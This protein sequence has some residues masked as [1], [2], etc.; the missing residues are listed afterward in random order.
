[1]KIKNKIYGDFILFLI[2]LLQ[3]LLNTNM[4]SGGNISVF[5]DTFFSLK[6]LFFL[7]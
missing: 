7:L 6:N 1:M 2:D 3:L 4:F 5:L